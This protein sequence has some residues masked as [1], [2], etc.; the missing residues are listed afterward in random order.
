MTRKSHLFET[1]EEIVIG[2]GGA[3]ALRQEGTGRFKE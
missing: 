3:Q 1:L 2:G